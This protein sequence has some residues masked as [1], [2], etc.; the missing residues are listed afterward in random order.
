M[1]APTRRRHL[2]AQAPRALALEA[3]MMFDAAAVADAIQRSDTADASPAAVVPRTVDSTPHGPDAR[4][5]STDTGFAPNAAPAR[6]L[7]FV[8]RSINGWQNLLAGLPA[9]AEVV[10]LDPSRDPWAQMTDA[11]LAHSD[12]SAV[13]IVSHGDAGQLILGGRVYANNDASLQA[14][15]AELSQWQAHLG[16]D[17]DILLY[18]CSIAAN[19]D[20]AMLVDTLARLTQADVAASTDITGN[21]TRADWVLEATTGAI[22]TRALDLSASSWQGE[23]ATTVYNA[24]QGVLSFNNSTNISGNGTATGNIVRFNSVIT[25]GGQAIDAVVTTTLSGATID[26]YDSTANPSSYTAFFQPNLTAN[27]AGGYASYQVDFYKAGTYTGVNTGE[28]VTLQN[29]VVN[30]YD[31]DSVSSSSSDRQFQEFKGFARYE[32][33]TSGTQLAATTQA[34]GSVRFQYSP[35]GSP[36]NNGSVY[37]DGYRVRVYYDSMSSFVV[38][39]GVAAAP[40]GSFSGTAYF[41]FDFSLGPNWNG[42]TSIFG[43][44]AAN[45]AYSTTTLTEASSNDGSIGNSSTITLTN[46]SFT[47]TDGQ[48]LSGVS[49]SNVPTGLTAVV[50]RVDATHATL[51]L[52][53]NASSHTNAADIGN[54]TVTFGNAAF[55]SGN[56]SA[57]TGST[58]SDL[59][60]DFADPAANVAPTVT[61]SGGSASFTE[62]NNVTSTPVAIDSALTVTDVDSATLAS[63]TVSI[64]GGFQSGQDLLAFSNS[65]AITYGNITASYNAGSGVL[66]LTSSGNTATTAQWQAALRAVTYT[67]SA[68][69]PDTTTR[70]VS[71]DAYDGSLLS[72]VATRSVT[73]T[74]VNDSPI[75]T[76]SGGAA[77]FVEG[78]NVASTPVAVDSALTVTDADNST[79]ASATVG[80]TGNFHSGE[81]ALA[82]SNNPATMGNIVASYNAGTGI[83]TLSSSGATATTAQW[84]AAL[85]SVTYTNGSDTPNT[86]TRTVSFTT[87]DGSGSSNTA[88]RSVTV[89]AANDGP[90][91]ADRSV[92]TAEDTAYTLAAADFGFTDVDG[93]ALSAVTITT[94]PAAGSL[95]LNGATVQ[96]GDSISAAAITAGQLVFAPATNANGNG[97]AHFTFQVQDDGGTANSGTNTD[98]TPNT[99]TFNVTSVNDAPAGA[100]ATLTTPQDT[101][102]TLATADFG[103]SDSDGNLMVA[104]TIGSV[105]SAGSLT[106]DGVTVLAGDRILVADIA[107]GKL[108][109]TPAASATGSGYASFT[110][111]VQDDGGSAH[112]GADTDPVANTV[113]IDVTATNHAPTLADTALNLTVLEDAAAPSGA[114]GALVGAFTGGIT[115]S[116]AGALQGLAITATDETHGSWYYSTNGG[117]TWNAVGSV[118]TSSALLLADDGSTRLYFRPAAD[119]NGSIPSGLTLRAWDQS[120]GTAG[121]KVAIAGTAFSSA[122]DTLTVSVTA[123]NDA[124]TG[125]DATIGLA[126]DGSHT[127]TAANFGFGDATDSASNSGADSLTAVTITTLP[128]AGSL[129]LDGSAVSAGDVVSVADIAAGKLI[130]T[131]VAN[132]N[133]SPYASF[134]FQVQDN[135]GTANSGIDTDP[136]AN[137]I[138]FNVSAVADPASFGSGAGVDAGSVTEDLNASGGLITDSGSLTVTDPDAG[139]ATFNAGTVSGSY[140][141]LTIDITGAWTYSALNSQAAIQA[142]GAGQSLTDTLTVTS[143]DGSSHAITITLHGVNDAPSAGDSSNPDWDAANGRYSV[144]TPEDTPRSGTIDTGDVDGNTLSFA[145]SSA[146]AHGSVSVDPAT[147]AWVYTPAANF[148]GNDAF[149]VTVS[150]GHGGSRD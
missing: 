10:T 145:A 51:T 133:G 142:L 89:A 143:A 96:A 27:S 19:S 23:L 137:T 30:S 26:S 47:G 147:G 45:L 24:N 120:T 91:G 43:T 119:Y 99:I 29:V 11:I 90:S 131:P 108:V 62:G 129:A 139:Q 33:V 63:A 122:D 1:N 32:V 65:S 141:D 41:A 70:T 111:Q 106:L 13:H 35:T 109:F 3:R 69:S 92:T 72:N 148:N 67:N 64:T 59:V 98:P 86:A 93:N 115:D 2:L 12:L 8:D 102:L 34:D 110:F 140:G 14:H 50:T 118:S 81:D 57:I 94:V 49:V 16:A 77:A 149:V 46:G 125:S 48:P 40:T 150:D 42:A 60:V 83:L 80:I 114:V 136:I 55:T 132:G 130:Y 146:P 79:L 36:T 71:F 31:I 53:G 21:S 128:T 39:A 37:A 73:L 85:R 107:A 25:I 144:S 134:T 4:T 113:T 54:L 103:F 105:P 78:A 95:R 66:T 58:R 18:G 6:E 15:S 112:G 117:S 52:T 104:L 84:Q 38:K 74:A 75:V 76:T 28:A 61:T 116:D 101:A 124:P 88:T 5:L 68:E 87:F 126:E 56:A 20:G 17:A 100:D 82:F 97:Y 121:S 9:D 135:G 7:V 44:P 138:T 22:E 123:V 127:L